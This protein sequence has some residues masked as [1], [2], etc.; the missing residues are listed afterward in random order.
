MKK[1]PSEERWAVFD[2]E[3]N[4]PELLAAGSDGLNKTCSEIC[5]RAFDNRTFWSEGDCAEFMTWLATERISVVWA[6]NLQYDLGNLFSG[7]LDDLDITLVGG[8]LVRARMDGIE[9]RDSFNFFPMSIEQ[10]GNE[11]GLFKLKR[12]WDGYCRRDVDILFEAVNGLYTLCEADGFSPGATVGGLAGRAWKQDGSMSFHNSFHMAY[13]ANI[14]GRV[15]LFRRQGTGKFFHV[16]FNSLYP[17]ALTCAMP[18]DCRDM[19]DHTEGAGIVAARVK[20]PWRE[21]CPL[22]VRQ[23]DGGVIYPHGEFNGIWTFAE[24]QAA[25]KRGVK[26]QRIFGAWGSR[27]TFTP[28]AGFVQKYYSKKRTAENAAHRLLFK[29]ILNAFAGQLSMNG[30]ITRSADYSSHTDC[31]GTIYG[32]KILLDIPME[33]PAHVNWL[34]GAHVTSYARIKLLDYLDFIGA[35]DMIYCD[36]DS[37]IFEAKE[38]PFRESDEIGELKLVETAENYFCLAPKVY[39]FGNKNVAKGVRRVCAEGYID[40]GEA[41]FELPYTIR[42]ACLFYD[43]GNSARLSA[44]RTVKRRINQKYSKKTLRNNRYFPKKIFHKKYF[45]KMGLTD[46]PSLN[47]SFFEAEKF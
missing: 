41:T 12:S 38:N 31:E 46:T 6:H 43:S 17:W 32:R 28:Y 40:R 42:E 24:L 27:S 10:L 25:E 33:L 35:R 29:G 20:V 34:H 9:F 14:G 37:L 18:T 5:A 8:R 36:T 44:W 26:I 39:R 30:Q 19:R 11:F 21:I 13:E 3:D 2:T 7:H 45:Q 47:Y 23:Y 16:D 4:S 22:P 1:N 15:E